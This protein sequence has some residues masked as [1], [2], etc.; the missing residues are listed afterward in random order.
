MPP[1]GNDPA[2]LR[3]RGQLASK[4]VLAGKFQRRR[5]DYESIARHARLVVDTRNALRAFASDMG[6]RLVKA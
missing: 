5:F 3:S 4:P 1:L 6:G 2:R